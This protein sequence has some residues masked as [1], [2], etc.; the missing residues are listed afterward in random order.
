MKPLI[1]LTKNNRSR[2]KA[3]FR[4]PSAGP[5]LPPDGQKLPQKLYNSGF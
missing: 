5:A 1:T 3:S 2:N 4:K